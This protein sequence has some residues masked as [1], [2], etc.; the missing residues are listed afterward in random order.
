M[1]EIGLKVGEVPPGVVSEADLEEMARIR[2]PVVADRCVGCGL[3]EHPCH[4][5]LVK[6]RGLLPTSA[7]VVRPDEA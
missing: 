4:A 7:I 3:C 2:A 6:Q 5:A 1:R